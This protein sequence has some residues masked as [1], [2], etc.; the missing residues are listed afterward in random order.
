MIEHHPELPLRAEDIRVI[1]LEPVAHDKNSLTRTKQPSR[2]N[3][4][5]LNDRIHI[6]DERGLRSAGKRLDDL[7][8]RSTPRTSCVCVSTELKILATAANGKHDTF[9]SRRVCFNPISY[10]PFSLVHCSIARTFF[11]ALHLFPSLTYTEKNE[12]DSNIKY[13]GQCNRGAIILKSVP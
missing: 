2:V 3:V 5:C 10:P 4:D 12:A 8:R 9:T 13:I 1:G 6:S 7:G 11:L